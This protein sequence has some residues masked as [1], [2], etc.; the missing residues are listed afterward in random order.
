[1]PIAN[2]KT[3]NQKILVEQVRILY[4]TLLPILAVNLVVSSALLSGLWNIV[5][6][7][8]LTIWM[9]LMVIVLVIRVGT[10]FIYRRNFVAEVAQRDV[11]IL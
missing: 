9:I 8:T 1:M 5:S 11:Y 7:T 6:Q 4:R 10:Y 3:Q 2:A